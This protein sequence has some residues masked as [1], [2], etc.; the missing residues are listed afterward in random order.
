[1]VATIDGKTVSGSRDEPV[2]DIGSNVDHSV[3]RA[4]QQASNAILIGAGALRS[5]PGLWYPED[6]L[7]IV[8]TTSGNVDFASRFFTDAPGKAIVICPSSVE[9]PDG[10]NRLDNEWHHV[11]K[12]L[13]QRW[14][15]ERLLVEGGSELNAQ[16]LER[17]LIDELFLTLAPKVKLG[18]DVPTYAGGNPLDRGSIQN[19]NLVEAH[20]AGD[21]MFLRYKRIFEF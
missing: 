13:K 19:Y 1:M 6:K 12:Q 21:E 18:R 4:L 20:Q 17:D 11:V 3:M 16:L 9:L 5:T 15:V 10:I 7:R 2:G 14:Q 8:A